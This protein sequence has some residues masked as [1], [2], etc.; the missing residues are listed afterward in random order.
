MTCL[1]LAYWRLKPRLEITKSAGKHISVIHQGARSP[2][3]GRPLVSNWDRLVPLNLSVHVMLGGT[4][5]PT[6]TLQVLRAIT[7]GSK[8]VEPVGIFTCSNLKLDTSSTLNLTIG[9]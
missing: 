3:T 6:P 5:H 8:Q 9:S 4:W 2:A 7:S 1:N